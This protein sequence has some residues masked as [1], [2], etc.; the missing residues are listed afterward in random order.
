MKAFTLHDGEDEDKT[1]NLHT[2]LQESTYGQGHEWEGDGAGITIMQRVTPGDVILVH[3]DTS[4]R[5]LRKGEK[6]VVNRFTFPA[7]H[8]AM[9]AV[10]MDNGAHHVNRIAAMGEGFAE[11]VDLDTFTVP[12]EYGVESVVEAENALVNLLRLDSGAEL[13]ET[14]VVGEQTEQE[15]VVTFHRIAGLGTAH[16]LLNDWFNGW[17]QNSADVPSVP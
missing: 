6:V 11:P 14:L 7:L 16:R 15:Q 3:D 8:R 10:E 4:I 13:F 9:L 2:F 1:D 5:V 12:Y 17:E